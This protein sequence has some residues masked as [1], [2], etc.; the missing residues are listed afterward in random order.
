MPLYA[1][2]FD[3]DLQYSTVSVAVCSQYC[4]VYLHQKRSHAFPKVLI[5]SL[6]RA[7]FSNLLSKD[8]PTTMKVIAV[9]LLLAGLSRTAAFVKQP[10]SSR[11]TTDLSAMKKKAEKSRASSSDKV[12]ILTTREL[13]VSMINA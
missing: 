2:A 9:L 8:T 6:Q 5:N 7:E 13:D 4:N 3:V 1:A 12:S 11:A 10:I